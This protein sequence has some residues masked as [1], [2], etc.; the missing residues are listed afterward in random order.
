MSDFVKSFEFMADHLSLLTDKTWEHIILSVVAVAISLVIAI[1]IGAWLGHLHR[2][3]FLAINVSNVGRAL[4]SLAVIAIMMGLLG[5]GFANVTVALVIL[6]VP[7]MLTNAYVAVDG[8]DRD[9]VEAAKGMGM[10]PGEVFR[11]IELPL[12]VPLMF[13]G[14]RT[15][16]VYVVATATLAA[17]AG[18]GG[19]GDIIVN[20]AS[21]GLPG[22]LAA[23]MWV[24][25]LALAADVGFGALQR[26]VTPR[27]VREDFSTI[28]NDTGGNV[29]TRPIRATLVALVAL[30]LAF[31]VAACG[32]DDKGGGGG[33]KPGA[34]KPAVTMGSKSFTEQTILGQLYSQAL[35]AKGY[36]VT[37]KANIGQTE[38]ADKALTSGKVDMYP[39]YTGTTLS[40]VAG[41]KTKPKDATDAY[42]AAKAF[43]EK[44]GETLTAPTPFYDSDGV[45]VM[46]DY[47]TQ[48]GLKA[49]PDLKK[50]GSKVTLAGA[51][52]FATREEGLLGLKQVYG[53]TEMKFK[54]LQIGL[55]YK[56]LD[57]GDVNAIEVFTTDGALSSGK[58]TVLED[59]EKVF[60]FQNVA[61]V[62]P[63]KLLKDLGPEFADT[64]DAVSAK[65]TNQAMQRMNAA[66]DID[67][68]SPPDVAKQFLGANGLLTG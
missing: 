12:S 22:V 8:V 67:K 26:A 9:A 41:Q 57:S 2:G 11:R 61:M 1:P 62:V 45:A 24:A 38:I 56:A 23:A 34:G 3:S 44:R 17:I 42:D 31:G 58:Y 46:K 47:A 20:Q 25:A 50:L 64:I 4:P 29:H 59:P 68:N 60:G 7:P 52:E 63:Q 65:L 32:D 21:Y 16:V 39:E 30:V 13:A 36:R 15:A 19:L 37:L 43:Y 54:P 66:V 40:V 49:I 18:G 5:L 10:R 6:A 55:Q 27:G 33:G 14:I 48:N 51:P 28:D 35:R 53:L